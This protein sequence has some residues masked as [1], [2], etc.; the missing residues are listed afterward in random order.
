[1]CI[2]ACS[3]TADSGKHLP[4]AQFLIDAMQEAWSPIRNEGMSTLRSDL[5]EVRPGGAITLI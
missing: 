1:L 3:F 2:D 4:S 5:P